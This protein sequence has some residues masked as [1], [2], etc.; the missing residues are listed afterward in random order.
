MALDHYVPQVHLRNFYAPSLGDRLYAV[1][2]SDLKAFTPNSKGVCAINDGSTNAFLREDRAIEEFLKTIEPNYD[3]AV[4]NLATG[5]IDG[6]TIYTLAGFVAS[7]V[8][9]SPTS[10]R[11]GQGPLEKTIQ[12]TA[13]ILEQKGLID[14]PPA[15]LAG[16]TL[17]EMIK[18][19]EVVIKVDPKYPQAMGI[20]GI[21][22]HTIM[23]GNFGWEVLHNGFEDSPFFTSDF[24]AAIEPS[25]DP[26]VLNRLV[27]LAP[28]LAVRIIPDLKVKDKN[29]D[30]SFAHF[31]HQ[32]RKA[33]RG[34]VSAINRLIV[35]CAEETVI[36]SHDRPWVRPFIVKNRHFRIQPHT[37]EVA[38]AKGS[39]LCF[40]QRV[41][42]QK[43]PG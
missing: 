38:T 16:K 25:V 1:R 43:Q 7:V 11:L 5:K 34:E 32:A 14:P 4:R 9:C 36:Y 29:P 21:M 12:A 39:M 2:K 19:G 26:R 42:E 24:P 10:M 37:Y 27:P 20:A 40:T 33:S 17:T 15:E 31:N 6:E 35:Q 3:G 13:A 22:Q 41:G 28:N 18:S 8:A 30:F 23:F